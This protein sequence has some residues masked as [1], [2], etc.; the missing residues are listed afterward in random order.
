MIWPNVARSAD[1][2]AGIF[3]PA[4]HPPTQNGAHEK[5]GL[6]GAH[7]ENVKKPDAIAA[8]GSNDQT[9]QLMAPGITTE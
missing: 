8:S 2:R 9:N 6:W 4:S 5:P 3:L 1:G 7:H